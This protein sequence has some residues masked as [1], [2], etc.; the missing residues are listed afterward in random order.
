MLMGIIRLT[1]KLLAGR[2]DLGTYLDEAIHLQPSTA[3]TFQTQTSVTMPLSLRFLL[4]I[5]R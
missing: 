2:L 5:H 4:L 1:S 3:V